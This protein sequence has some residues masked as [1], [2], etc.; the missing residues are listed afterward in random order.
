MSVT[1]SF[2]KRKFIQR[3]SIFSPT[4]TYKQAPFTFTNKAQNRSWHITLDFHVMTGDTHNNLA[5]LNKLIFNMCHDGSKT[6]QTRMVYEC[7]L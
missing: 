6:K 3:W 5:G 2:I 1:Y 4:S 7:S